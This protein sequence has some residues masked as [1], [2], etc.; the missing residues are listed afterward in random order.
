M[1]HLYIDEGERC[2]WGFVEEDSVLFGFRR[3][4]WTVV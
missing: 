3:I 1:G 2:P 4:S